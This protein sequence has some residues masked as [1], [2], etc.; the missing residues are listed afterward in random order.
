MEL[1]QSSTVASGLG[2]FLGIPASTEL[3][4]FKQGTHQYKQVLIFSALGGFNIPFK[5]V[6]SLVDDVGFSLM[7][8][9]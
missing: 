3:T 2:L 9:T 8:S 1:C 6:Y 7:L 4:R 5:S